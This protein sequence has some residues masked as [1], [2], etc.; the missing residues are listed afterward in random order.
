MSTAPLTL[1]PREWHDEPLKP[2]RERLWLA[3]GKMCHW[4]GC[5]T[6]LVE[7]DDKDQAT[8]DHVIPRFKGGSN[9]DTNVVSSCRDCNGR[10]NHEDMLGL[11]EGALLG[12]KNWKGYRKNFNSK[13]R[14]AAYRRGVL[15]GDEKKALM[16]RMDKKP[17]CW[18]SRY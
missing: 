16:A 17:G 13:A 9:K 18:L 10:R 11:P 4:C 14:Y 12:N 1:V 5:P 6:R 15:T 3:A 8:V 7:G 2:R